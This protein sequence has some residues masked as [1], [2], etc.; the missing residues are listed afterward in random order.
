MHQLLA[1]VVAA[2]TVPAD[3]IGIRAVNT[4]TKT[5][6][7]RDGHPQHNHQQLS[8]GAM[9]EVLVEGQ[10]GYSATNHLSATALAAAIVAAYHQA[11]AARTWS[12]HRFTTAARP[13]A[14]GTYLTDDPKGTQ[15]LSMGALNDILVQVCQRL[16]LSD[17][18]AQTSAAANRHDIETWYVSSNGSEI[19]QQS[20]LIETHLGA[21][22]QE[23]TT[24]QLRT[25]HGYLAHS[26]QGGWELFPG[27]DLWQ[28]VQHVGEQALELLQADNCP[29]I[30]TTLVLAPDQM[31]LQIHESI[32]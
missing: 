7:T 29:D 26:Y 19:Y 18:I 10:F 6:A 28:R 30:A 13:P 14:T 17:Q 27:Q 32:G 12:V 5:C 24:T 3:W 31:M 9:V 2:A 15:A 22:A 23:G 4:I 8:Q 25:D 11:M 21:I 1:E 16:K 20:H